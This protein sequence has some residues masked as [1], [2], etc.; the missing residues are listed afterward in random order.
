MNITVITPPPFEPVTLAQVYA[1]LRLSPDHEG[2]PGEETHPDDAMLARHI[3]TA[4][5]H[6]EQMARR[7]LVQQTLRLSIPGFPS[8]ARG[9]FPPSRTQAPELIRLYRPPVLRVAS[10]TYVDTDNTLQTLASANYYVTDEQVPE[11]R[12][13][14]A[15][16][17]PAVYDR[18]DAVRVNYVA[19][20]MPNGSPPATQDDFAANVPSA[21]RDAIL[22]GVQLLYDNMTPADAAATERMRECLVQPYRVQLTP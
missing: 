8:T 20:Y 17:A 11:L 6:V 7:S 21:L 9:T 16:S 18:P 13:T 22:I 5:Q 3:T 19:G 15:F 10:V 14:S 2:S 1:H 12:F 4:R